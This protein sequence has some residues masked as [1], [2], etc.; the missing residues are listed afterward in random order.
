M[1]S[2]IDRRP[3][4]GPLNPAMMASPLRVSAHAASAPM[5]EVAAAS[6]PPES[7]A[8]VLSP[9]LAR[10][11]ATK[12]EGS[13][14]NQPV[15]VAFP[16]RG[17]GADAISTSEDAA[18]LSRLNELL[19][20]T[21]QQR[22]GDVGLL[23]RF[24]LSYAGGKLVRSATGQA[25]SSDEQQQLGQA[26]RRR[27]T[28]LSN[29]GNTVNAEMVQKLG[30]SKASMQEWIAKTYTPDEQSQ[31]LGMMLESNQKV[32]TSSVDNALQYHGI[33]GIMANAASTTEGFNDALIRMMRGESAGKL[34]LNQD[35]NF[36]FA[37]ILAETDPA[38]LSKLRETLEKAASPTGLATLGA[39]DV[40]LLRGFGIHA[41]PAKGQ[42]INLVTGNPFKSDQLRAI[43]QAT[44]AQLDLVQGNSG[45][46]G[47]GLDASS[48][49]AAAKI[50]TAITSLD[51]LQSIRNSLD[52]RAREIAGI[53][54]QVVASNKALVADSTAISELEHRIESKSRAQK[55]TINLSRELGKPDGETWLRGQAVG[56]HLGAIIQS[57]EGT[58]LSLNVTK[59]Q[60]T[61]SSQGK[62]VTRAVFQQ[63]LSQAIGSNAI[64]L[65]GDQTALIQRQQERSQHLDDNEK[66]TNRLEVATQAQEQ[67]IQRYDTELTRLET[68][69]MPELRA[70]KDDPA[71]WNRLPEHMRKRIDELLARGE[72]E[73]R[74]APARRAHYREQLSEAQSTIRASRD[75]ISKVRLASAATDGFLARLKEDLARL[76]P[77]EPTEAAERMADKVED[78]INEA[79][80]LCA[81]LSLTADP[82]S[83]A[84]AEQ[85]MALA[86][87]LSQLS[88]LFRAGQREQESRQQLQNRFQQ[89]YLQTSLENLRYHLEKLQAFD[90]H[91]ELQQAVTALQPQL[92]AWGTASSL[93]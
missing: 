6:A 16:D 50:H 7:P 10:S 25:L 43:R 56:G 75:L 8:D 3:Q 49:S 19:T 87:S 40:Q 35:A 64:S 92:R 84:L 61:Y 88:A 48:R 4:T 34:D 59:D 54:D 68:R 9:S 86:K 72:A 51:G 69:S 44:G 1:N 74:E 29:Q 22:P 17:A 37:Q 76:A 24:G 70:L 45:F 89:S 53:R 85:D 15:S 28:I 27:L 39:A 47:V 32:M 14:S 78:L 65:Q 77:Q 5:K 18:G 81:S 66:L 46:K 33:T 73:L 67:D 79:N 42:C 11:K 57:L 26:S 23:A 36:T 30:L 12:Q 63:A 2:P 82:D 93:K 71:S 21:Q 90:R 13:A 83:R 41:D 58:G 60:V 31:V 38:K 52:Q 20:S 55:A 91:G 80:R 62:R